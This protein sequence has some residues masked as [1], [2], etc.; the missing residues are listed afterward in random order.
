MET[1]TKFTELV[2][3]FSELG[4]ADAIMA[5]NLM[6]D[7]SY[8]EP[9][10]DMWEFDEILYGESP[11]NLARMICYG[12]FS[13]WHDYFWVDGNGNLASSNHIEDSPYDPEILAD[14]AYNDDEDF[15]LASVR[16]IL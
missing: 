3:V 10:R 4:E 6:C 7:D 15:G 11:S 12:D 13:P 14:V 2:K 8:E 1:T 9:I 5:W 16:E